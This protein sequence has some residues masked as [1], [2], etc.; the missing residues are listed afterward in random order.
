MSVLTDAQRLALLNA[1][2]EAE[3]IEIIAAHAL[4]DVARSRVADSLEIIRRAIRLERVFA[5]MGSGK[6]RAA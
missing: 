6:R 2:R 4:S 5:G 1:E 3:A